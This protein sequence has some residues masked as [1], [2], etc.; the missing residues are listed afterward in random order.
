MK[1]HRKEVKFRPFIR[2]RGCQPFSHDPKRIVAFFSFR[3]VFYVTFVGKV[4]EN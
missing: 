2:L 4:R 1:S 3:G